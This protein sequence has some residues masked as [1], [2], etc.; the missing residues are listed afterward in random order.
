VSAALALVERGLVPDALVRAGIRRLL[1]RRLRE[2]ARGPGPGALVAEMRRS[3]I[4]VEVRAANEQHYEVAP[5]FFEAV[6]G[7]RLKYSSCLYGD[8]AR[9]LAAAEEAMLDLTAERAGLADGQEVLELG[10]GWGSFTLRAAERFPRSRILGV[11]N[12]ALQREFILAR[13]RARGLGNVA[14][15][16]ADANAFDPGRRF[17]RVVSVEMFE[18]MRNW[19]AL[20]RRIAGW[21]APGGRLF[22]HHFCH[23]EHAYPFETAGDHNWMGRHFF[24]G[25][26]M[27]SERLVDRFDADLVVEERWRVEG[28]HYARTAEDWLRNLDARRDDARRALAATWGEGSADLWL[29]R[30]RVFFMA[31]AELF[32]WDGGREWF[33]AHARLA[34]RGAGPR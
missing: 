10:C 29:R 6:L 17:D 15:A 22:L 11:S 7:P 19:E 1:R 33:V 18:H 23:R 8:G 26:L 32:A 21:L 12:S 16:T 31:C 20:L 4:A 28:T 34:P 5:A 24:T 3:P 13:A 2:E 25:G 27:P 14:I 30:W 9:D